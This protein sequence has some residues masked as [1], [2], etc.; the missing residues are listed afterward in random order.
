VGG[1]FNSALPTDSGPHEMK[2]HFTE[3]DCGSGPTHQLGAGSSIPA[4]QDVQFLV[5]ANGDRYEILSGHPVALRY[6]TGGDA[7]ER[8]RR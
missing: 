8:I 2:K 5:V 3:L 4:S 7:V 6:R 1:D